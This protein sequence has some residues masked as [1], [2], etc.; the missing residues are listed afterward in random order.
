[1]DVASLV[2]MH[3][4][5]HVNMH[6]GMIPTLYKG[7]PLLVVKLLYGQQGASPARRDIV[8]RRAVMMRSTTP[9]EGVEVHASLIGLVSLTTGYKDVTHYWPRLFR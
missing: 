6:V 9:H 1:M 8:T 7:C 5:M 2:H 4:H 3:V